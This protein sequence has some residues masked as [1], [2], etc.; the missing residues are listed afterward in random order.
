MSLMD[1]GMRSWMVENTRDGLII[2]PWEPATAA[3]P[4]D[5]PHPMKSFT[6][7]LRLSGAGRNV[8][9]RYVLTSEPAVQPDPFQPYADRA[10]ARGWNV[11]VME[12]GHTPERS[13][14][15]ELARLLTQT[16]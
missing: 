13:H 3:I 5:V 1:E 14:P 8:P 15:V 9:A 6:D 2:P 10:R 16:R 4:R 11:V 12:A 7:S